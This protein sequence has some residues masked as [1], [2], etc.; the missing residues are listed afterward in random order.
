MNIKSQKHLS[1][2]YRSLFLTT[3]S[4]CLISLACSLTDN[5]PHP[6]AIPVSLI[7]LDPPPNAIATEENQ[8]F[9]LPAISSKTSCTVSASVLHLRSCAGINCSVETWLL[10]GESLTILQPGTPWI[11]V[12]T[13]DGQI[14]WV[15]ATYCGD[16]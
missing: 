14:G 4:L 12:K 11:K 10:Q 16:K 5:L 8:A 3:I 1:V 7:T 2:R 9:E 15:N 6:S 13:P